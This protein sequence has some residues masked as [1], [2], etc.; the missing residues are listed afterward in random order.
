VEV[1]VVAVNWRPVLAALRKSPVEIDCGMIRT[2]CLRCNE[3]MWFVVDWDMGR[4]RAL[5]CRWAYST[6]VAGHTCG[7]FIWRAP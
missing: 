3:C 6:F 7:S 4:D 2:Q 1:A 5:A